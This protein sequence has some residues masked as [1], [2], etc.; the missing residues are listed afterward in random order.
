MNQCK[1]EVKNGAMRSD[2]CNIPPRILTSISS[3]GELNIMTTWGTLTNHAIKWTRSWSELRK[4]ILKMQLISIS[5]KI[6]HM[7]NIFANSFFESRFYCE[8][9]PNSQSGMRYRN[10]F[11]HCPLH[12]CSHI[13]DSIREW[14]LTWNGWWQELMLELFIFMS[15]Q[16]R[17]MQT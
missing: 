15:F 11:W 13:S 17:K 2:L 8:E 14:N 4:N 6:L 16:I 10:T 9:G 3:M 12:E 7:Q 1:A 5:N